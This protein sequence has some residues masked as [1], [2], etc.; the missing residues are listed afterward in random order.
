MKTKKITRVS[1]ALVASLLA[2]CASK[3]ARSTDGVR[4]ETVNAGKLILGEP[5]VSHEG[6]VME[7]S[8]SVHNAT[9]SPVRTGGHV[10]VELVDASNQVTQR[11]N[12]KLVVPPGRTSVRTAGPRT[13]EYRAKLSVP[14]ARG[15]STQPADQFAVR[16]QVAFDTHAAQDVVED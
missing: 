6:D 14:K 2:G 1:V 5:R 13:A 12:A 3:T 15:S 7:V 9:W 4:T 11:V 10:H 16:V 8:G